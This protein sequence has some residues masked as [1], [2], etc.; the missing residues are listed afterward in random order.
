MQK[1]D[2]TK[3]I[4]NTVAHLEIC[5]SVVSVYAGCMCTLKEKKFKT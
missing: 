1:E 3:K 2:G 4:M 5:Y